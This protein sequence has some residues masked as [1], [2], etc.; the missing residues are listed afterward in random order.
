[1]FYVNGGARGKKNVL[2]SIFKIVEEN[3]DRDDDVNP[4]SRSRSRSWSRSLSRSRSRSRAT[5][6][7]ANN[8]NSDLSDVETDDDSIISTSEK[9]ID[10]ENHNYIVALGTS[11]K[12]NAIQYQY[13]FVDNELDYDIEEFTEKHPEIKVFELMIYRINTLSTLPFTEFLFYKEKSVCK[14]PYYNHSSKKHIRNECDAIMKELFSSKFRFKGYLYDE[15]TGK[16]VIFYEKYFRKE[17]VVPGQLDLTKPHNWYWICFSEIINHKRYVTLPIAEDAI[18]FFMSYPLIGVLQN[19]VRVNKDN[20]TR[21]E[22][23]EV[24]SVLYY[25]STLCYAENTSIYGLKR[26]PIIARFGPFYYFTTLEHS[27][28]WACY[29]NTSNGLK[30]AKN[31]QGGISRYAVF[32]GRMKT[33]FQDDDYDVDIVRKYT[34]RKNIFE[35]RINQYRQTQEQYQRGAYDSIYSYDYTW[36]E[37]YDTIYNGFYSAKKIIRP[38]WCVCDYR[39]FQLLSYYEVLTDHIPTTYDPD[40]TDYIIT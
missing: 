18:D 30:H 33:V 16:C 20:S 2:R 12:D 14:L 27:Y 1:M 3:E 23:I 37:N 7:S 24:P 10:E 5:I 11:V 9:H 32:T 8:S 28:Y 15:P 34:E 39:Q 17:H 36:P 21:L 31:A 25:G 19:I 13:V 26:E 29:H 22:N 40:F 35:T 6:H 4:G 38:V